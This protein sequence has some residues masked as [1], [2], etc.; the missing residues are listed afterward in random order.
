MSLDL[1]QII[2]SNNLR[3]VNGSDSLPARGKKCNMSLIQRQENVLFS[4]TK[5]ILLHQKFHL[6]FPFLVQTQNIIGNVESRH[7]ALN[8]PFNTAIFKIPSSREEKSS[9]RMRKE[10]S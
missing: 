5:L 2:S 6:K 10:H 8:L 9:S 7:R 1:P 3:K 4:K